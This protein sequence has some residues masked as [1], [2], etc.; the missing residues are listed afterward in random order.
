MNTFKGFEDFAQSHVDYS[1]YDKDMTQECR[2]APRREIK[3]LAHEAGEVIVNVNGKN[4]RFSY[5]TFMKEA[6]CSMTFYRISG[7]Y[8][9]V[10]KEGNAQEIQFPSKKWIKELDASH[11][12]V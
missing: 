9:A 5:E 3:R 12:V 2:V 4:T 6:S 10:D 8:T 1:K 11:V 7:G